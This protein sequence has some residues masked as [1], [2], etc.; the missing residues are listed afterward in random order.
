MIH[1]RFYC[2]RR[3]A[4]TTSLAASFARSA[5]RLA[6]QSVTILFQVCLP[7]SRLRVS[8]SHGVLAVSSRTVM[9]NVS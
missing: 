8:V 6:A 3:Y 1:E 9:N 4:A 7:S 5:D 2:N